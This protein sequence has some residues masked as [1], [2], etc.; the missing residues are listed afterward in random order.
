MMFIEVS[1]VFILVTCYFAMV[2]TNW[3]TVQSRY[4]LSTANSGTAAMWLQASGQWVAL[5]MYAWSL[6]A[7]KLFPDRDFSGG[8]GTTNNRD[9][10]EQS[11]V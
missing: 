8:R 11:Q 7:P 3:A 9:H 2:L 6:I 5:A 10:H 4:G 1:A